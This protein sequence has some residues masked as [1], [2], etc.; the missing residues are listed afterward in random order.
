MAAFPSYVKLGTGTSLDPESG[1]KDTVSDAGTLHSRQLHGRQY[2][3][4]G[5]VWPG[6]SG[7]L[8]ND[9]R[10][11]YESDARAT[12][13]GF[14]YYLSSPTLTLSVIMTSPPEIIRNYGGDKY[15]V[16]VQ[17]RGWVP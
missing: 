5:I 3:R 9:L 7:Q 11:L 8:F 13:T 6:V 15:D 17:L 14:N 2:W 16:S 1:W 4:V 10:V 12:F